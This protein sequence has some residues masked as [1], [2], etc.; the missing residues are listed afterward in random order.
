MIARSLY[1]THFDDP[2]V[3]SL[4]LFLVDGADSEAAVAELLTRVPEGRTVVVRTNDTLRAASLDVFDR[5]FRVTAVLRLLA[6]VVAF[7][8]VLS[9]LAALQLER[10]RELGLL[11]A[12]GLTPGQLG[13]LVVTQT[14]LLGLA[15]GLLALPMGLVLSVVM[16]HVVNKRSFGWTLD[17]QV[18][19]EVLGQALGLA[20]VGALLA[21]LYPAWRMSRAS[22]ALALRGE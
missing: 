1:D 18:G 6:F 3:T 16:I 9:A 15:S 12:Q 19:P 17:M 13:G 14:G 20:L 5:T 2:G 11:R 4:G 7:V 21:G 22:P 8:G 10:A